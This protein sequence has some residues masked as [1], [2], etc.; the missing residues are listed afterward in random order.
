VCERERGH[1]ERGGREGEIEHNDT[2]NTFF[3]C[4]C[5]CLCVREREGQR[6]REEGREG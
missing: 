4:V 2:R 5:V 6:E 1:R 3:L